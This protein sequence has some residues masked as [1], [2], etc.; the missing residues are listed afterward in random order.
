MLVLLIM[1]MIALIS[2]HQSANILVTIDMFM[3]ISYVHTLRQ[4]KIFML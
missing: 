1:V 2:F 4:S 3:S